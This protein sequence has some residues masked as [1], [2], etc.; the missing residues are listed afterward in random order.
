MRLSELLKQED[1]KNAGIEI[2]SFY[3][4]TRSEYAV[5]G[6]RGQPAFPGAGTTHLV[7]ISEADRDPEIPRAVELSIKRRL[8]M[9]IPPFRTS[10]R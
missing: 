3:K 5:L 2:I 10:A 9:K 1:F 6:R 8:G 4:T 7:E